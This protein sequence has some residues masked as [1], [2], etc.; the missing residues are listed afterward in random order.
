MG[1]FSLR[2]VLLPRLGGV[3]CR[4]RGL[5][6]QQDGSCQDV[7]E[8]VL[9]LVAAEEFGGGGVHNEKEVSQREEEAKIWRQATLP[10]PKG[11]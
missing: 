3:I 11:M 4:L 2:R 1:A 9:G 5:S 8:V 10:F 6:W 7:S